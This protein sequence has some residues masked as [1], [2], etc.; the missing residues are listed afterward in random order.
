MIPFI[1][2]SKAGNVNIRYGNRSMVVWHG[3]GRI[4]AEYRSTFLVIEI[5]YILLI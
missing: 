1:S 3:G 4:A 2:S 5:S